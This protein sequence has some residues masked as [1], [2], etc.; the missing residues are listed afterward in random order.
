[1]IIRRL[2][3]NDA[4]TIAA[5]FTTQGWD[6]PADQYRRYAA[7]QADGL[8]VTL[9]AEID[10]AFAG[11]LNVVWRSTYPGFR[12]ADIPEITDFNVL[13]R[14]QRRGVGTLLMDAAEALI[15]DRSPIAGIG[16]GLTANYGAAQV[17][18]ARRGYVPDGRGIFRGEQPVAPGE[19]VI[20]GDDLALYLMRR[21]R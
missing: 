15:A 12:D 21:L 19:S 18:Y 1:M 3:D 11:Y 9:V 4:E 20:V 10:G 13:I 7:E 5:A 8:R 17:L 14:Y 6:K 2:D 16:V